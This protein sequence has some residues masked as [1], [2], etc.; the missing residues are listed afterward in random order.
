MGRRAAGSKERSQNI[1]PE[2]MRLQ[3]SRLDYQIQEGYITS[4][5]FSTVKDRLHFYFISGFPSSLYSYFPSLIEKSLV[6]DIL[7]ASTCKLH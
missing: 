7:F 1:P 4:I 2:E 3:V 5:F 6:S